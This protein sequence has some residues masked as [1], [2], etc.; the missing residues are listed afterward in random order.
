M[1]LQPVLLKPCQK[2]VASMVR[3]EGKISVE[4]AVMIEPMVVDIQSDHNQ[5]PEC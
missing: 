3:V 2:G 5:I 1:P 4:K